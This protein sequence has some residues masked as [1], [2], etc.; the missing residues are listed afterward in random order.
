VT[1]GKICEKRK[2]PWA[3]TRL[4]D[5]GR[6]ADRGVPHDDVDVR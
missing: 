3:G 6:R 1:C 5:W 4:A 2:K